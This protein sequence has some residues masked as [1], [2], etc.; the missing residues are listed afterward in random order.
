[1]E[2]VMMETYGE[3][4][5]TEIFTAFGEAVHHWES[6]IVRHRPDLSGAGGM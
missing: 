2:Q 4:E 3:E 5:A 6:F 1:M